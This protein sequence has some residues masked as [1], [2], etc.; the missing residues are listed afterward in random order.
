MSPERQKEIDFEYGQALVANPVLF[1]IARARQQGVY[2]SQEMMFKEMVARLQAQIQ[3]IKQ[4]EIREFLK[5]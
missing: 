4:T 5:G 3:Q 2:P 1:G